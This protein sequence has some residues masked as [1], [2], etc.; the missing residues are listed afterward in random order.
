M[1]FFVDSSGLPPTQNDVI[2]KHNDVSSS[3]HTRTCCEYPYGNLKTCLWHEFQ[4]ETQWNPMR[5]NGSSHRI[6]GWNCNI[7]VDSRV[8]PE[9]DKEKT[10]REWRN[11]K[12]EWQFAFFVVLKSK[13]KCRYAARGKTGRKVRTLPIKQKNIAF[14]IITHLCCMLSAVPTKAATRLTFARS[15]M[16]ANKNAPNYRARI[17]KKTSFF[18]MFLKRELIT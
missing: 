13:N 14:F 9:N 12:A 1:L 5:K 6:V 10:V 8:K 11:K 16:R 4:I 2:R 17:Y 15:S 7:D 3:C 18:R